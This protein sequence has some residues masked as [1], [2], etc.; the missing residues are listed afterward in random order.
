MTLFVTC[1]RLINVWAPLNGAV[2]SHPLA[3]ASS[4]SVRDEDLV[5]V[6]HR[7]PD[8]TGETVGVRKNDSQQWYYWSGTNG[9]E[10]TLLECFDTE[11]GE[12]GQQR[13]VAHSAFEDPRNAEGAKGRESVEVRCLIFG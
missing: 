2:E 11:K 8:R 12:G 10:R 4:P 3:F 7:Y 9:Q 6:E 1:V 13:R 5:G